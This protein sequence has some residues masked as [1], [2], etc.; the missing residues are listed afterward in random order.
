MLGIDP[1]T[2]VVGYGVV[3]TAS[4]RPGRLVECGVI[5]TAAGAP[6]PARLKAIHEGIT[7]LVTRHQPHVMAVEGVFYAANARTTIT[8]GQA[9]GVIL[10]AAEQGRVPVVE[11]APAVIKKTVVDRGAAGKAQ[12]GFMVAKLLQLKAAPAPADAADGVAVALTHLLRAGPRV[13]R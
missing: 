6:L 11:Y 7:E 8:L 13:V 9:R 12:V 10:L 4:G 5:K 1:G 2:A 3:E